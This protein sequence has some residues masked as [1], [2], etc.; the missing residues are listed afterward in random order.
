MGSGRTV[1]Q[2]RN[3]RA[4]ANRKKHVE[5]TKERLEELEK[6]HKST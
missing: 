6:F 5:E 3:K 1:S 2:M 4:R